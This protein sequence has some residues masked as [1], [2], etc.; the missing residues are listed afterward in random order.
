MAAK[1]IFLEIGTGNDLHGGDYTKAAMRAIED[2]TH[3]SSLTLLRTLE[4]D[5]DAMHVAVHIG[6]QKPDQ[7][8][9]EAVKAVLPH[10]KITVN[11]VQGGL[12]ICEDGNDDATV[13]ASAAIAV[14]LELP[15][16]TRAAA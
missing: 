9:R 15:A 8:D 12:D 5:P 2:A 7:V 4:I 6:V 14:R 11:V 16:G 1:Q 10:G 13:I 3:H